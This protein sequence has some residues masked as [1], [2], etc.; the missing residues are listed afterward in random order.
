MKNKWR[1]RYRKKSIQTVI[2]AAFSGISVFFFLVLAV[3][4]TRYAKNIL[5]DFIWEEKEQQTETLAESMEW[6]FKRTVDF[7]DTVYYG[8]LKKQQPQ[9]R[10]FQEYM[11]FACEE[12]REQIGSLLL[13]QE[14]GEIL[15]ERNPEDLPLSRKQKEKMFAAGRSDVGK[16]WFEKLPECEDILVYR[17][18]EMN[19]GGKIEAAI[20]AGTLRYEQL[21]R[22]F[23]MQEEEAYGYFYMKT[24]EGEI[25][26]HPKSM[27]IQHGVYEERAG[28]EKHAQDGA[29][30][31]EI[32]HKTYLVRQ[33]TVGYTGW[34]IIGVAS[35]D[36]AL[37]AGYPL[38]L[39]IW[40][41]FGIMGILAILINRY[42]VKR[43]TKPIQHLSS[44][45]ERFGEA[46][47]LPEIRAEGT[48]EVYQLT[49]QFNQ[50]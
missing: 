37:Y 21:I 39:L 42:I 33:R 32:A 43:I 35:L 3:I 45:V 36:E 22:V 1:E 16:T 9:S 23:Q 25:L 31:E 27:Q 17:F 6:E 28:L 18:V 13:F 40:S 38:N 20:L 7:F 41:L 50:M 47:E 8:I 11:D 4:F 44:Q 34:K 26:Y 10:E 15:Y 19:R 48:Y 24:A 2:L 46:Q 5:R 30:E 29:Y 12:H 14:S 49:E